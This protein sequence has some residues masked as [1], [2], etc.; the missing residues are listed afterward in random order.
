[1]PAY[2]NGEAGATAGKVY[3][4]RSADLSAG[5]G[6]YQLV[7]F[8][9]AFTG[10]METE[11]AGH[12]AA[13]AGDVDGDGLDDMLISG[14]RNDDPE[15]D[16]G[17]IYVVL[18][19]S[20]TGSGVRSLSGADITFVGEATDN[21]LGHSIGAG[22]DMD[23]DGV[24][25]LLMGSYGHASQGMNTGKVYIVP[26]NSLSVGMERTVGTE[27]YM[28]LGEAEEDAAG[29][30]IRTAFDVDGDGLQDAAVGARVNGTGAFEG[31]KGYVILGASLGAP[32]EVRSLA[33]ADYGYYGTMEAGWLGYQATGAGDVDGDGLGDVM[34][35]AHTSDNHR[36]RVYLIY[37]ASMGPSLQAA[38]EADVIFEGQGWSDHA[39]R[40]IAPAGE[41]DGDG[42][43]DL[44]IGARNAGDRIGRAYLILG[45]S[46][47]EGVI[48]LGDADMRFIG[49]AREDEAGYTVSSAGDVNGDGLDDILV[50]SWQAN[51]VEGGGEEDV[52]AGLAYLILVP[53]E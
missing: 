49:E 33:D 3:L 22:G 46:V 32:G 1:V 37:G 43:A 10:G 48:E 9:I 14:Y 51:S 11:E 28:Y 29:H 34:Y 24:G 18:G 52:G 5:P 13:P 12:S 41:V 39:G 36:G 26:G 44:L 50:A 38:D 4:V 23:G 15:R 42:R 8:P 40:S 30:A 25:E 20:L 7:D 27:E 53:S 6:D 2:F 45:E 35:G 47:S 31:G 17:R 16:V 19:S 21:R